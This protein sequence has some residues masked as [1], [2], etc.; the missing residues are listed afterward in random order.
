MA[1]WDG[2]WRGE[3]KLDVL[4]GAWAA[5]ETFGWEIR[6]LGVLGADFRPVVF[7]GLFLQL[8]VVV[9]GRVALRLRHRVDS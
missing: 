7:D 5:A 3:D 9:G 2:C 6:R 1:G 8:P 4:A